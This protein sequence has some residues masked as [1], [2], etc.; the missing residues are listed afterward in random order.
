MSQDE[1]AVRTWEGQDIPS[2]NRKELRK[3]IDDLGWLLTEAQTKLDVNDAIVK[4]ILFDIDHLKR[5][6]H[7]D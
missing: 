6:N 3:V 5:I 4:R 7:K 2:L 1:F